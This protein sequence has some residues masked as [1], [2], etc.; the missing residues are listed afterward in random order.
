M[1]FANFT[2]ALFASLSIIFLAG[3]ESVGSERQMAY[4]ACTDSW[5]STVKFKPLH[6]AAVSGMSGGQSKCYFAWSSPNT[7]AAV[8]S[9]TNNCQKEQQ[10]CFLYGTDQGISDWT[11]QMSDNGGTDG[12][13]EAQEA[14][15][16]AFSQ[17]AANMSAAM[18][19]AGM[20]YREGGGSSAGYAGGGGGGGSSSD[21]D[22]GTGACSAK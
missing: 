6:Y 12:S 11:R 3:C 8:S 16:A 18:L 7:S 13:R 15:A 9:A 20:A 21:C 2:A 14:D 1:D 10:S 19:A 5:N 17:S 22:W 4:N